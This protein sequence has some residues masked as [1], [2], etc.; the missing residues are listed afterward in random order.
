[1]LCYP[2]SEFLR[3]GTLISSSMLPF[4]RSLSSLIRSLSLQKCVCSNFSISWQLRARTVT[5]MMN[6]NCVCFCNPRVSF[7]SGENGKFHNVQSRCALS[8]SFSQFSLYVAMSSPHKTISSRW[9]WL[10]MER[11]ECGT[12]MPCDWLVCT[13]IVLRG[14]LGW[15]WWR[16]VFFSCQ[17][18]RLTVIQRINKKIMNFDSFQTLVVSLTPP[19]I[20]LLLT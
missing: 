19:T 17:L 11:R 20:D 14:W 18:M 16:R 4:S 8:W 2:H 15:I 9:C 12:K 13:F 1:M 7:F 3:H 10:S 5:K 6:E